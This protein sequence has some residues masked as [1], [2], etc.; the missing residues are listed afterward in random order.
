LNWILA[1]RGLPQPRF[2]MALYVMRGT[3]YRAALN[4][5]FI[6]VVVGPPP[7]IISEIELALGD[8]ASARPAWGTGFPNVHADLGRTPIIQIGRY[9]LY[10]RRE[11]IRNISSSV[12]RDDPNEG[13]LLQKIADKPNRTGV[14]T[15]TPSTGRQCK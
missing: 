8:R 6:C 15:R 7:E 9:Y 1:K 13:L 11:G 12:C 3:I 4:S 14:T 2:A 5:L 10:H